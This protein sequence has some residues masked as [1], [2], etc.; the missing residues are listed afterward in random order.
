MRRN[1]VY[2][3]KTIGTAMVSA[4]GMF[5]IRGG[6][7]T[8]PSPWPVQLI[9]G[10]ITRRPAY[11]GDQIAPHDYLC[12][13]LGFDHSVV[14]GAPATRFVSQLEDFIEMGLDLPEL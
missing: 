7:A 14:D 5:G 10:G 11:K 12:I 3:K 6:W 4:I 9:I 8:T 13:T 1:P 2:R